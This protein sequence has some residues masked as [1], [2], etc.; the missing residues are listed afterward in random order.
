MII[1]HNHPSGST[2]PSEHDKALTRAIAEAG[3][4]LGIPLLDHVIIGAADAGQSQ[5]YFSFAENNML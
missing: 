4:V 1:A 2:N 5:P 3:E